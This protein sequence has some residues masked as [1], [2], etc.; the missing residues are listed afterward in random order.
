MGLTPEQEV[1]RDQFIETGSTWTPAWERVLR[2]DTSY[3]AAYMKLH[4]AAFNRRTLPRKIQHLLVLAA[5][6][7]CC[8]EYGPGIRGNM[9]AALAAG[10]TEVEILETLELTSVLGIHSVNSGAPL[11]HEV[12]AEEGKPTIF[13]GES[14]T[15]NERQLDLI[16]KFTATRGYWHPGWNEVLALDPD[17][18]EAY[19]AFSGEPFDERKSVFERKIKE[20]VY[21]SIDSA[22]THMFLPGLKLHIRNAVKY[23]AT[24][25]E[26]MEVFELANLMGIH[27][28]LDGVTALKELTKE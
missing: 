9:A 14:Q 21:I 3:F 11:L 16:N 17:F 7:S 19:L 26:I 5:D 27:T 22:S 4:H 2:I 28:M 18:L 25:Q 1:L 24:P 12:L 23:G 8:T 10:A 15:W 20:F 6:A 13:H